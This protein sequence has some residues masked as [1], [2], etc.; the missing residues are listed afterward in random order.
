LKKL[1]AKSE[2]EKLWEEE[3]EAMKRYFWSERVEVVALLEAVDP[4]T[5]AVV[6]GACLQNN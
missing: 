5:S 2:E 6:Q 1:E 4:M 3:V